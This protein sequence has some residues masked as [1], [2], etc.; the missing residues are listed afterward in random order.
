MTKLNY[1]MGL[2]YRK[3]ELKEL[4]YKRS[5]LLHKPDPLSLFR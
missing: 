2:L 5:I 1:L 4:L 3:C